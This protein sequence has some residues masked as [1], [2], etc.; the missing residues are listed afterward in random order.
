VTQSMDSETSAV[1]AHPIMGASWPAMF[2]CISPLLAFRAWMLA[3]HPQ[4][5]DFISYW[6]TGRVFLAGG[7]PYAPAAVLAVERS[8]GWPDGAPPMMTFCPPW[9]LP[10]DAISASFSFHTA[11]TGWLVISL[12]L[13]CFSALGLWIYFGGEKRK[14]W[15]AMLIAATFMPMGAAEYLGQV[16]PLMLA[17]LVATLFLIRSER[18]FAIGLLSLGFGFKPHLLYLVALA[19]LFWIV[20]KRAWTMLAGAALSYGAATATA[21]WFNPHSIDYL[22]RSFSAATEVSC[23][24]GGALR[25][26]FGVQHMW[27]QFLPCVCGL[28]WFLSYWG[29]NRREWD[30]KTH[31]PLLL[32]ISL[33]TS[34]YYWNHDFILI[35]PALIA[36]GVRSDFPSPIVFVAYLTVQA[37]ALALAFTPAWRATAS[38]LWVAFYWIAKAQSR[39]GQA[40]SDPVTPSIRDS[41][42]PGQRPQATL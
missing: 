2:F 28:L 11:M 10:A 12:L 21:Q 14:A 40:Y 31:L 22:H 1:P 35:L 16:T 27:L 34:P 26:I 23:G 30:W 42:Y 17:C 29:K 7:H 20:Q 24:F 18:Y 32:L 8:V 39:H 15:I 33:C 6:A 9:A 5:N 38:I 41:D 36:V 25:S 19:M 13:D 37:I 4:L 3:A